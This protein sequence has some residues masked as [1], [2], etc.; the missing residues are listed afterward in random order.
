MHFGSSG[1]KPFIVEAGELI[2]YDFQ[3]TLR[4]FWDEAIIPLALL[5]AY[6]DVINTSYVKLENMSHGSTGSQDRSE[7]YTRAPCHAR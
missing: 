3:S 5:T 4:E 7:H 1:S 2:I 6:Y